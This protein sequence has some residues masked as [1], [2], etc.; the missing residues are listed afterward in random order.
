MAKGSEMLRRASDIVGCE[1]ISSDGA[2]GKVYDIVF[3]ED[4]VFQYLVIDIGGWF[5]GRRLALAFDVVEAIDEDQRSIHVP[6]SKNDI[7]NCPNVASRNTAAEE[8]EAL[9]GKIWMW[10]PN[11]VAHLPEEIRRVL[12]SEA[13]VAEKQVAEEHVQSRLRSF[14]ETDG[15]HIAASDGDIGHLQDLLVDGDTWRI[16]YLAVNAGNWF[17]Q[18]NVVIPVQSL[19]SIHWADRR[20]H[21]SLLR[22]EVK[23]S[24]EYDPDEPVAQAYEQALRDHY[25]QES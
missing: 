21:L 7:E 3:G 23:H 19:E 24:P 10:T 16:Q 4:W 15:Y 22:D 5:G 6:L 25:G 9:L 13:T 17:F 20:V 18:R 2:I 11:S 8:A 12:D 1:I 14:R